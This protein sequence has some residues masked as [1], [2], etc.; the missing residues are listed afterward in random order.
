MRLPIYVVDAFAERSF[1]GNPAGV[2]PLPGWVPVTLMQSIAAEMNLSETAFF[3]ARGD[4]FDI[5]WFTPTVEAELCG[6][7]TLASAFVITRFLDPARRSMVFHSQGG[8]L[9]V[10]REG[11]RLVLDFPNHRPRPVAAPTG[12]AAALGAEPEAVLVAGLNH[13]AVFPTEAAVAALAP[14]MGALTARDLAVVATAP[15]EACDFVS[16]YFDPPHGIPEDPVTGSTHCALVPYWAAR[17]GKTRL[18]ARQ[19]SRRGGSLDCTLQGD[20]V[21]IAGT[22]VCTLEGVIEV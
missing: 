13:Y 2:V 14:D 8:P 4:A 20:R 18:A 1:A 3:V 9:G 19:I 7:A 5:R 22:A 12:L 15:G 17:L 11:E 6:H 10:A 21:L 16:R